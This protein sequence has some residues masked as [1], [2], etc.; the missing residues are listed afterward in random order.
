MSYI[1]TADIKVVK[2]YLNFGDRQY[3]GGPYKFYYEGLK[4]NATVYKC[5]EALVRGIVEEI[6]KKSP[7]E[8]SVEPV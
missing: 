3:Y 2:Y 5:G 7:W 8:L 1:I 6:Q 4:N